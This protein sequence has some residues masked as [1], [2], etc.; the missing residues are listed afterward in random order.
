MM[1]LSKLRELWRQESLSQAILNAK[2]ETDRLAK[3][4]ADDKVKEMLATRCPACG[5]SPGLYAV[6]LQVRYDEVSDQMIV[7]CPRCYFWWYRE[8][9]DKERVDE[10]NRGKPA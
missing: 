6:P 2:E 8:L 4:L 5:T 10:I 7:T 9:V 1:W 3:Q